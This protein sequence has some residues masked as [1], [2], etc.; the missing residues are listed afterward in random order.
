[1]AGGAL[2]TGLNTHGWVV[3]PGT[4]EWRESAAAGTG[5]VQWTMFYVPID[6][7]LVS[8]DIAVISRKTGP[9]IGS[10]H[11]PLYIEVSI[12]E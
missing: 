10:D 4:I 9:R 8:E 11:L 5:S 1:M 7:C 2:A 6:H 3:P 12:V